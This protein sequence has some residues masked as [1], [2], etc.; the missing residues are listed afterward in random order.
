MLDL[1]PDHCQQLCDIKVRCCSLQ[2][3]RLEVKGN[4]DWRRRMPYTLFITVFSVDYHLQKRFHHQQNNILDK[5]LF[6]QA[7]LQVPEGQYHLVYHQL[8]SPHRL[9]SHLVGPVVQVFH[10]HQVYQEVLLDP[11]DQHH[12]NSKFHLSVLN[13]VFMQSTEKLKKSYWNFCLR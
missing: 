4:G 9:L 13:L 1:L 10:F 8:H 3:K 12:L 6:H 11:V 5:R 7:F 2:L